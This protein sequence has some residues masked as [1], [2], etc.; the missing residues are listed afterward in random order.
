IFGLIVQLVLG[1]GEIAGESRFGI[2][3]RVVSLDQLDIRSGKHLAHR[4]DNIVAAQRDTVADVEQRIFELVLENGQYRAL[5]RVFAV[6]YFRRPVRPADLRR[7]AFH[8]RANH[9]LYGDFARRLE[10]RRRGSVEPAGIAQADEFEAVAFGVGPPHALAARFGS[11][12]NRGRIHGYRFVDLG[13]PLAQRSEVD[14]SRAREDHAGNIF[15][16]RGLEDVDRTHEVQA[17]TAV[18]PPL[19]FFAQEGGQMY[20]AVAIV[21]AQSRDKRRQIHHVAA[22][23]G[24]LRGIDTHGREQPLIERNVEHHRAFA[25]LEQHA[26]RV[27]SDQTRAAGDENTLVGH[28]ASL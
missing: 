3:H 12:I 6:E 4:G 13:D 17:H 19:N 14:G 16:A 23:Q 10:R 2:R 9:L 1:P 22:N 8:G 25:A 21:V 24:Y 11:G 7:L 27:G 20:D 26:H 15:Q 28:N 5:G 18:G